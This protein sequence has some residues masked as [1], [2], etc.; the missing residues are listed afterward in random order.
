MIG[1]TGIRDEIDPH[2]ELFLAIVIEVPPI[3]LLFLV[4]NFD[5]LIWVRL[6][7]VIRGVYILAVVIA[8]K[9]YD[10]RSRSTTWMGNRLTL[11]MRGVVRLVLVPFVVWDAS[12]Q[13]RRSGRRPIALWIE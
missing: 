13:G 3:L 11:V 5:S 10:D 7:V 4:G 12:P 9:R 2:R 1:P 8:L 6:A